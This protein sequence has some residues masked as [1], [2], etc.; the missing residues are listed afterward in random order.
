MLF[1][2]INP[3]IDRFCFSKGILKRELIWVW[4]KRLREWGEP[5]TLFRICPTV[6]Y[7]L[8]Y[9]KKLNLNKGVSSEAFTEKKTLFKEGTLCYRNEWYVEETKVAK[10]SPCQSYMNHEHDPEVLLEVGEGMPSGKFR[11]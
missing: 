11:H 5:L 8:K 4:G 3:K 6:L 7:T 10:N 1:G 9:L 2:I